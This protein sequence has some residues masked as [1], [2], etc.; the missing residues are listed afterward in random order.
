MRAIDALRWSK[1]SMDTTKKGVGDKQQ[2]L[3]IVTDPF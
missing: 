3:Y 2:S 1:G